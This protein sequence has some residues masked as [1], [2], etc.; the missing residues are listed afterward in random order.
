MSSI[1]TELK[2]FLSEER[3]KFREADE[4]LFIELPNGFGELQIYDLEENDDLVGLVGSDWHTHSECLG[5]PDTRAANVIE[6]LSK[7]FSGHYLLIEEQAPGKKPRKLIEEDLKSYL[8]WLPR[9]TTYKVFN[10]T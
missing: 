9:N 6:F 1:I 7:I 10:K 8:K 2:P 4:S 3:C 5:N